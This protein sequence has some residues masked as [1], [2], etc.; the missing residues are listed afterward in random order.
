MEVLCR[1]VDAAR[2]RRGEPPP[3]EI[4]GRTI[5]EAGARRSADMTKAELAKRTADMHV[6]GRSTMTRDELERA[7][8]EA[9]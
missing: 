6:K 1:S 3:R 7:V 8:A 2:E 5:V 4:E 9:A